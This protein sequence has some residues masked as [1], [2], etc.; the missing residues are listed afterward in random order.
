MN[1]LA[2]RERE[3]KRR[4]RKKKKK[5]RALHRIEPG[6][7]GIAADTL[8]I[9]KVYRADMLKGPGENTA[10]SEHHPGISKGLIISR[11]YLHMT[12][13]SVTLS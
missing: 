8:T 2:E 11:L 3:K 1:Y 6:S 9:A 10:F 12:V 13:D 7:T 4:E 5:K